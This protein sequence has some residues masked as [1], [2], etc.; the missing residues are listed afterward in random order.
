ME[1]GDSGGL[2]ARM[3]PPWFSAKRHMW[4]GPFG[5]GISMNFQPKACSAHLRV[6]P[7]S[8]LASSVCEMKPP[9]RTLRSAIVFAADFF[10]AALRADADVFPVLAVLAVF[11]PLRF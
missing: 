1:P 6:A 4:Y 10:G 5:V 7:G 9:G 3:P 11:V 2:L 8:V